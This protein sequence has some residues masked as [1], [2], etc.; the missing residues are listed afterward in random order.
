MNKLKEEFLNRYN[1]KRNL[2]KALSSAISAAVQH[3]SLYRK[4]ATSKEKESVRCK[5]TAFLKLKKK[6]YE[7][8]Q[9]VEK[10]ENDIQ[11]LSDL[12][13]ESF[14]ESFL[15]E[16]HQK[17]KTE[18]GFR[19]SHAQKSLSVFLKHLWC[20]GEAATPPQ[21]PV[22]A[23]I[24]TMA[25]KKYPNTKWGYVNSIDEHRK[26]ISFLEAATEASQ[27]LAEWELEVFRIEQVAEP[28]RR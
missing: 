4:E 17:F 14:S 20:M 8:E 16:P 12:M 26:K 3:N 7:N 15:S 21:C 10:Y 28:D 24:L 1:P 5:W 18:P 23:R 22:D 27:S 2:E 19:I 25:G 13:N 6:D 9:T 11:E